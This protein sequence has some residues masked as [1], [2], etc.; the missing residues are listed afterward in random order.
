MNPRLEKNSELM[1]FP[2]SFNEYNN[3]L[4]EKG[5]NMFPDQHEGVNLE[6]QEVVKQVAN[7]VSVFSRHRFELT[8]DPYFKAFITSYIVANQSVWNVKRLFDV[9][10]SLRGKFEDYSDKGIICLQGHLMAYAWFVRKETE[11][12]ESHDQDDLVGL[13]Q[14][15]ENLNI[16][17]W[18]CRNQRGYMLPASSPSQKISNSTRASLQ[19]NVPQDV[20]IPNAK[21]SAQSWL[22]GF[23]KRNPQRTAAEQIESDLLTR[24]SFRWSRGLKI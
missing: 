12:M 24:I 1:S 15:D 23:L 17:A 9:E 3:H 2:I 4:L 7:I 8:R 11:G 16:A 6:E 19:N 5:F 18:A 14:S 13:F 21:E 20:I 22:H 10:N